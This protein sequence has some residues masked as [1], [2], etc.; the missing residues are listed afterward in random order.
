LPVP[1]TIGG[2]SQGMTFD[3]TDLKTLWTLLLYGV[4][5]PT[6]TEFYITDFLLKYEIGATI[7]ESEQEYHW[8]I[9]QP[10]LLSQNS[11]KIEYLNGGITIGDNL[12]NTSIATLLTPEI[13]FDVLTTCLFRISATSTTQDMLEYYLNFKFLYRIYYGESAFEELTNIELATLR[14]Q[15]KNHV[16]GEY[17]L[18]ASEDKYK[19]ICYPAILGQKIGEDS[20]Y[21]VGSQDPI[22]MQDVQE[23]VITNEHNLEI[24]YYCYR[25]FYKLNAGFNFGIR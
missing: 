22:P 6:F 18:L 8:S 14:S 2:I 3:K 12:P 10:E 9:S 25:S 24:T 16:N 21:E 1:F 13:H 7:P 5:L 20:F 17:E 11:I 4:G 23:L 15:L 19:Y